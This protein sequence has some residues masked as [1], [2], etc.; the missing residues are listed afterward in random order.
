[1]VWLPFFFFCQS[2]A[3]D[4]EFYLLKLLNE[5]TFY[6][7]LQ[8]QRQRLNSATIQEKCLW[9]DILRHKFI[10]GQIIKLSQGTNVSETLI[11]FRDMFVCR[12]NRL[13]L[14]SMILAVKMSFISYR[15]LKSSLS[16]IKCICSNSGNSSLKYNYDVAFAQIIYEMP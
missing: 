11:N 13:D 15:S 6:F 7:L 2:I 5:E 4:K 12:C 8:R 3:S 10:N 14:L 16:W 1:M 9:R